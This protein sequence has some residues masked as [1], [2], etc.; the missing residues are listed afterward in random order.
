MDIFEGLDIVYVGVKDN[1]ELFGFLN[2]KKIDILMY[3]DVI[4]NGSLIYND[5]QG[6]SGVDI[7]IVFGCYVFLDLFCNVLFDVKKFF[8]NVKKLEIIQKFL[9]MGFI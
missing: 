3:L 1:E 4:K 9:M 7:Y 5:I 6:L 2:D 8:L